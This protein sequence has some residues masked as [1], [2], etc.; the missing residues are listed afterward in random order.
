MQ[1][2]LRG[3]GKPVDLLSFDALDHQLYDSAARATMLDRADRH[4]RAATGG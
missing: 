3:A 2:R 4:I 1:A